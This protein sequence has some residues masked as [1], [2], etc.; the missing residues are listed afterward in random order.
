MILKLQ[1][2]L[3]ASS[4]GGALGTSGEA[5]RQQLTKFADAGLVSTE[6]FSKG[7]GRPMQ[8]WS[9]TRAAEQR[10]PDTHA[11]LSVEL[12]TI[13]RSSLGEE[14]LQQVITR[15]EDITRVRYQQLMS[16]S[17]TLKDRVRILASLRSRDGYM[18][19][20]QK[21]NAG[22]FIL[23]ENHCPIREAAAACPGLY[24]AELRLFQTVLGED[25]DVERLEHILTGGRRSIYRIRE[26][27][28]IRKG[29]AG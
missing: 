21:D 22:A 11:A 12:L 26:R 25:A 16:G 8:I 1:G 23:I 28:V 9:L 15:R 3:S 19:T 17:T 6:R 24:R 4:L 27:P 7:V 20:I 13:L 2:P 18:A 14:A 29:R 10:F 5:A